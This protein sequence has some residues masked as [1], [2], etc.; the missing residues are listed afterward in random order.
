VNL[1]YTAYGLSLQSDIELPGLRQA[2]SGTLSNPLFL[3]TNEKPAWVYFAASL[4]LEIVHFV[5]AEPESGDPVFQ[6]R[7]YGDEQFYELT[8]GDGANFFMDAASSALWGE[9]PP[10]LTKEDLTTYLVGP[11]LG[12]VLRRRGVTCLHA[13]AV[14]IGDVGVAISGPAASGKSTTAAALAIRGVPVL[15]ED[16]TALSERQGQFYIQPGYPR[17]CLWPDAVSKLY[18]S[19]DALPNL[20][21]TWEKKF[22]AL[23]GERAKFEPKPKRLG[24]VYLLGP[25]VDEETA[26][27]V[28]EL[29]PREA[30]LDLVQNTYMNVL[31][32]RE[33]RAAEFELLSRLVNRVPCRRLTPH[34]DATRIGAL[35]EL[36][37]E[38]AR[39]IGAVRSSP[40]A[41][42]QT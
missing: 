39:E 35:C 23:D 11:V 3:T 29:S 38:D 33:Q 19:E 20:T 7:R 6:V 8:Y 14:S 5:P 26:P 15:C 22:L 13:S 24:A 34:K 37:Q 27:R 2:A 16:I 36:I 31:L 28:T 21:P 41:I 9:C 25:R 32:T 30:L 42:R 40:I 12:F 18:G 10:P 4:P 17:V 1:N